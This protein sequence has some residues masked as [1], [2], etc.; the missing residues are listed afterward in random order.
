[1]VSGTQSSS[2]FTSGSTSS[3]RNIHVL[4][5][6]LVLNCSGQPFWDPQLLSMILRKHKQTLSPKPIESAPLSPDS[7]PHCLSGVLQHCQHRWAMISMPLWQSDSPAQTPA[8]DILSVVVQSDH[9]Q[10]AYPYPMLDF[11]NSIRKAFQS[12]Y[13]PGERMPLP[14]LPNR[15][16]SCS[17]Y[18]R[19]LLEPQYRR[20]LSHISARTQPN[21]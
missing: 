1:M 20:Q 11:A 21:S 6:P 4:T 12:K 18:S 7:V 10:A 16:A 13:C 2:V 17:V 5:A 8:L 3:H 9:N 19:P 14:S 15:T